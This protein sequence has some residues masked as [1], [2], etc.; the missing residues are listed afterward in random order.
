M[1]QSQ[2]SFVRSA[3]KFYKKLNFRALPI[4]SLFGIVGGNFEVMALFKQTVRFASDAGISFPFLV[5]FIVVFHV[6]KRFQSLPVAMSFR[7]LPS[8]LPFT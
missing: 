4:T 6:F 5:I 7:F 2:S 1:P 8:P 3:K